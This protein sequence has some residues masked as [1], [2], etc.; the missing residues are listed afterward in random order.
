VSEEQKVQNVDFTKNTVEH[1]RQINKVRGKEI[2][3]GQYL[4]TIKG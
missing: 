2:C 1:R 3:G 4:E